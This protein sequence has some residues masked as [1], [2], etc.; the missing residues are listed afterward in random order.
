MTRTQLGHMLHRFGS[1]VRYRVL[2]QI[3]HEVMRHR[4]PNQMV[5]RWPDG[6]IPLGPRVCV[7]AHWDGAGDVREHVLHHLRG[8]A[9]A[10]V[11]V[12]FVTNAGRLRPAALEAVKLICA[13]VI[14]RRNV[15]YDFGAWREGI[16]QAAL[17]RANT[18]MVL[19]ANDSVYG[20]V[21]P[22]HGLLS[23]IDFGAADVWGCTESWQSRYHLQSYLMAFSPRVV[24]SEAWRTFWASVRPTWAKVWLIRLYELGLTQQLLRAG[25]TCRA[26]WPYQ[27][28]VR[29][30]DPDLLTDFKE[31]GPNLA[32]PAVRV[33]QDHTRRVR[34][35]VVDRTPLNPT[36]DLWRQLMAAGFP[37]IKRELL[38]D[39][40][41]RVPDVAEW[42][43][44][45]LA[46][47][48]S[49]LAPI[50]RDLQR[51]LKNKAP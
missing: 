24:A 37:F 22:L 35:H 4:N 20:P 48:A 13:G 36:S 3:G 44:V 51:T 45:A 19:I 47:H 10:G 41:S 7:Y 17:P 29:D 32:D 23:R 18:S 34:G 33:R 27:D 12:V 39:N 30:L 5:Q 2:P 50:E 16:E 21:R 26:I 1:F 46:H 28:L 40:P 6:E 49:D 38:R 15:G 25:F 8:L 43:D 9:A 31:G 11:S 42:R 14:V